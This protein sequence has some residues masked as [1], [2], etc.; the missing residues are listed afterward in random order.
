MHPADTVSEIKRFL[1]RPFRDPAVQRDL[2]R[3]PV[4]VGERAVCAVDPWVQFA[5]PHAQR[6]TTATS[7]PG[8]A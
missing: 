7:V 5:P 2:A 6:S 4:K 1:G 3:L 8:G